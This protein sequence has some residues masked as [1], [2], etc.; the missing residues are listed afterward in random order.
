MANNSK[1]LRGQLRQIAKEMLPELLAS[2]VYRLVEEKLK[3]VQGSINETLKKMD[4][5]SKDVQSYVMRQVAED[6]AMRDAA[7]Q[8]KEVPKNET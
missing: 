6:L 7:R 5:R 2:E 4:D 8:Q 3:E 1:E